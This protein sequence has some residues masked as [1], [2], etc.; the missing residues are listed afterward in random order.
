MTIN[1][2]DPVG[3]VSVETA[4]RDGHMTALAAAEHLIS[5]SPVIPAELETRC[6]P[7][8]TG[9]LVIILHFFDAPD[10]VR[11]FAEHFDLAVGERVVDD[12][13]V[14]EVE[15]EGV[16]SGVQVRAWCRVR[17]A[18]SVAVSAVAA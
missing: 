3:E 16:V 6:R 12:S 11:A 8:A 5:T 9:Q 13:Q 18:E 7:W 2:T 10:D 4:Q 14:F 15:A 17:P 1:L